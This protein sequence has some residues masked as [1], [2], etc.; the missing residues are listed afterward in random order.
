[1]EHASNRCEPKQSAKESLQ[2]TA[3][4]FLAFQGIDA[5]QHESAAIAKTLLRLAPSGPPAKGH[6]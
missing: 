1:M 5:T 2:H 4:Q 6:A 3:T